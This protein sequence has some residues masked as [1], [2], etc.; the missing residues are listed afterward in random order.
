MSLQGAADEARKRAIRAQ[1]L[2][3]AIQFTASPGYTGEL[4]DLW[5]LVA[6]FETYL[7]SGMRS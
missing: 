7:T 4:T 1:A 5:D 6:V 2:T 3:A